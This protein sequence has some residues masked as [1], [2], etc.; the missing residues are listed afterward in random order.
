MRRAT[1]RPQVYDCR[2]SVKLDPSRPDLYPASEIMRK[3]DSIVGTTWQHHLGDGASSDRVVA[4]LIRRLGEDDFG[5]TSRSTTTWS[6]GWA[7]VAGGWFGVTGEDGGSPGAEQRV[8]LAVVVPMLDERAVAEKCVQRITGM[9]S[10]LV[11]PGVLVVVDDGSTDGTGTLLD[12][13]STKYA[14]L[15]VVHHEHNLGYWGG[16]EE[17]CRRGCDYRRQLG[18]VHGQ[19]PDEPSRGHRSF[20]RGGRRSRRLRESVA[21]RAGGTSARSAARTPDDL[22]GR[23]RLRPPA[24]PPASLRPHERLPCR[25]PRALH[26]DAVVRARVPP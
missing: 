19:R 21:V 9:L 4:D 5:A 1:E 23:E 8:A 15:S 22:P 20:C 10:S 13:F 26:A 6:S 25:P 14:G 12:G 18:V 17:R 3:L 16:A 2:S 11:P 24:V 7:V